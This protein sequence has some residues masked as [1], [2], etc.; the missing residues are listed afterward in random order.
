MAVKIITDVAEILRATEAAVLADPIRNTVLGSIRAHLRRAGEDG[1][2][3]TD[4]IALAARSSS[5]H[6]IALTDGWLDLDELAAAIATLPAVAGLGGPPDVVDR[7]VGLLGRVPAHRTAERLY[8]LD[9]LTHPTGVA[10]RERLA[11]AD[12]TDLLA[13]WYVAFAGEAHGAAPAP[14]DAQVQAATAVAERR[15]WLWCDAS[16]RPAALAIRQAP[17]AGV[18]RIGPVYTPAE[19]RAR[20]FGSAVTAAATRAVLHDGAV[21]VLYTDLANPTSNRIYQAIGYRPVGD[22]ASVRF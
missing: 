13:D 10:G 17:A 12:D 14:F 8:R 16:G 20:G 6:P 11:G 21:P 22:R 4:G 1:W 5:R 7:L 3:A 2:C 9:E 18:S 15:A 19:K